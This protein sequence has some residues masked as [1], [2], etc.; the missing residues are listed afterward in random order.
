MTRTGNYGYGSRIFSVLAIKLITVAALFTCSDTFAVDSR[1]GAPHNKPHRENTRRR[2]QL[3]KRKPLCT[4]CVSHNNGSNGPNSDDVFRSKR[5][6]ARAGG[7]KPKVNN[8]PPVPNKKEVGVLTF[9]RQ[10]TVPLLLSAF[11]LRF[12]FGGLF[13]SSGNYVY[14]SRSV[15]QSITYARDGNVETKRKESFQSN[16]PGLVERSREGGGMI[17]IDDELADF[18]DEI[19]DVVGIRVW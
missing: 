7:R 12:V 17:S 10:W 2:C 9:L 18:E 5:S 14:Y 11:L 19:F 16:I 13:P 3:P 6:V 4:L 15:Y 8:P 1:L